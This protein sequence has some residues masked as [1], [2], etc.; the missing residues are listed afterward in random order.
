MPCR[1]QTAGV[2][3]RPPGENTSAQGLDSLGRRSMRR[4]RSAGLRSFIPQTSGSAATATVG[5][6]EIR[7]Q[8]WLPAS[9]LSAHSSARR[10]T[11]ATCCRPDTASFPEPTRVRAADR[12]V[13]CRRTTRS[14]SGARASL[15]KGVRGNQVA[16]CC[17]GRRTWYNVA[18]CG[19]HVLVHR[20]TH[21]PV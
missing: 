17:P 18:A 12:W 14:A 8:A 2:P 3:R 15:R 11:K 9:G 16:P 20:G 10:T 19:L 1:V 4:K 13:P 21:H 7:S 6:R 5:T